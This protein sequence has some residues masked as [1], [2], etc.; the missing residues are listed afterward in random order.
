MIRLT[1]ILGTAVLALSVA[2]CFG[3][4]GGSE[5]QPQTTPAPGP[6]TASNGGGDSSVGSGSTGEID[7]EKI[8]LDNTND[9]IPSLKVG[10]ERMGCSLVAEEGQGVAYQCSAGTIFIVQVGRELRWTCQNTSKDNC[11][12]VLKDIVDEALKAAGG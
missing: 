2:G 3:G 1:S 9:I 6:T 12:Q 8:D 5:S 7:Y 11:R 4:G 10:A